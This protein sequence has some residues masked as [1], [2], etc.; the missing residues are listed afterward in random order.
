MNSSTI[1]LLFAFENLT[2]LLIQYGILITDHGLDHQA[3]ESPFE[4][5]IDESSATP[6]RRLYEKEN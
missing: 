3:I 5:C 1:N 4:V 2:N 6:G